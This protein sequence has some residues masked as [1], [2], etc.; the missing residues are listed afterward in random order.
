MISIA[1]LTKMTII[2]KGSVPIN[3]VIQILNNSFVTSTG[4]Q[5]KLQKH[6][7][8]LWKQILY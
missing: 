3:T 4:S 7:Q 6:Q 8:V 1:I 2:E 5:W